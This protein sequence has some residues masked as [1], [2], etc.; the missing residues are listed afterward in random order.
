MKGYKIPKEEE[1]E[2]EMSTNLNNIS[3]A[4]VSPQQPVNVGAVCRLMASFGVNELF[5]S[6]KDSGFETLDPGDVIVD[7]IP[8]NHTITIHIAPLLHKYQG[9]NP[10]DPT[11]KSIDI[12]DDIDI[13][14]PIPNIIRFT[15]IPEEETIEYFLKQIEKSPQLLLP[16]LQISLKDTLLIEAYITDRMNTQFART[17]I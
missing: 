4:L 6:P 11:F 16:F 15:D 17:C 12:N 10:N 7:F 14:S 2:T 3:I 13:V 5:I 9:R 8:T 1:K